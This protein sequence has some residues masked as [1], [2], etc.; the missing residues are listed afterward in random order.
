MHN[1]SVISIINDYFI[2]FKV[3]EIPSSWTFS[4][5]IQFFQ[6]FKFLY[7]FALFKNVIKRYECSKDTVIQVLTSINNN[8]FLC[9]ID[10]CDISSKRDTEC[11]DNKSNYITNTPLFPEIFC[12]LYIKYS[13]KCTRRTLI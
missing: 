4:I 11:G 5:H 9:L 1:I 10:T 13:H 12:S 8:K 3:T 2:V 7:I 6:H